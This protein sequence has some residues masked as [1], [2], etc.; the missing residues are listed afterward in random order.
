MQVGWDWASETHDITV[1]DDHGQVV[2][3]WSLAHDEAGVDQAIARLTG[4]GQPEQ[5]PVAIELSSGLVVDRLLGAGHPVVPIHP[6]AF[7]ATRPRWGA[8]RAK[9]DPGDSYKLAD[10]LRTDGHRLRRLQP[11]MPPP[12]SCKHWSGSAP[13][14]WPPRPP[15]ATSSGRCWGRTGPAP[16]RSGSGWRPRSRWTS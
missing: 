9:S 10:Y 14:T 6:S 12:A 13:T 16:E 3:R 7:H 2:D 11:P 4:H 15:P 8:A 1:I 5:L